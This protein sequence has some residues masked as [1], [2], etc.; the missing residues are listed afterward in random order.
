MLR[1]K[2]SQ[3]LFQRAG[4]RRVDPPL[5]RSGEIRTMKQRLPL[6]SR[7]RGLLD[8]PRS[9]RARTTAETLDV[10]IFNADPT[11]VTPAPSW[12]SRYRSTARSAAG[13]GS[14]PD[15]MGPFR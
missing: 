11:S 6:V 12:C 9:L 1:R 2:F 8:Q 5:V 7:V 3:H 4:Y 10:F 13:S 14:S 15:R